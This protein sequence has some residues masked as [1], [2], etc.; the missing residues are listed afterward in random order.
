MINKKLLIELRKSI[1]KDSSLKNY[2][3]FF[4]NRFDKEEAAIKSEEY[5]RYLAYKP[6]RTIENNRLRNWL[7]L[8]LVR[9][10]QFKVNIEHL[11]K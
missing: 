10:N 4:I 6:F 3:I 9:R 2:F 1:K 7:L 8:M 11:I 5:A